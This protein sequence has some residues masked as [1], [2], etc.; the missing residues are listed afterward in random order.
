VETSESETERWHNG[1]IDRTAAKNY[2][3]WF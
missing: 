3:V 1:K 2:V